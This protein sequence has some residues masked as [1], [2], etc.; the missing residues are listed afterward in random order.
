MSGPVRLAATS[1]L[2]FWLCGF[3]LP[4]MLGGSGAAAPSRSVR[5]AVMELTNVSGARELDALGKGL[6]SLLATDLA[7]AQAVQMVERE[8]LNDIL[9]EARLARAG[10]SDGKAASRVGKLLGATHLAT[11][12][13]AV[14]GARLR[15]DLRVFSVETGEIVVAESSEGEKDAFFEV[16]GALVRQI[17]ARLAVSLEPREREALARPQ[18]SS[19]GAL[20]DFSAGIDLFDRQRYD[21]AVASLRKAVERDQDFKLARAT[22]DRYERAAAELRRSADDVLV[23]DEEA[24]RLA[25]RSAQDAESALRKQLFDALSAPGDD[26]DARARRAMAAHIL[27]CQ[28]HGS[29]K[30]YLTDGDDF[31]ARR[32]F[33]VMARHYYREAQVVYPR[34][35]LAI[36]CERRTEGIRVQWPSHGGFGPASDMRD[37]LGKARAWPGLL[38]LDIRGEAEL[39]DRIAERGAKVGVDPSIHPDWRWESLER[40]SAAWQSLLELERSTRALREEATL[41][42]HDNSAT[43]KA[44]W[45]RTLAARVEENARL[46]SGPAAAKAEDLGREYVML[47]LVKR[48][49]YQ[50]GDWSWGEFDGLGTDP[51]FAPNERDHRYSLPGLR[52]VEGDDY[53]L[54]GDTP[55]W[56]MRNRA[57]WNDGSGPHT[58]DIDHFWTGRRRD[59]LRADE[60]RYYGSPGL[61]AWQ[62]EA[63]SV[64][65]VEGVPRRELEARFEIDLTLPT[66][67]PAT[68]FDDDI[69]QGWTPGRPRL[70]FFFRG[71][72]IDCGV[73]PMAAIG[74][75]FAGDRVDLVEISV[76]RRSS[77]LDPPALKVLASQAASRP[78]SP[79]TTVAVR[80]E[81]DQALV[82][83]NGRRLSFALP[84]EPPSGFYGFLIWKP[85][86]VAIRDLRAGPVGH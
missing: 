63:S 80:I 32:M 75:A 4:A 71:R 29:K 49:R 76:R 70:V 10:V 8:H 61:P 86:F 37:D 41:P 9:G 22:L 58:R 82:T 39:L 12:S 14:V 24:K 33:E 78:S 17:L 65:V 51:V 13:F 7:K 68:V 6:Q 69:P 31:A 20:R 11:G 77:A 43:D 44:M 84:A 16:E 35:P 40:R 53:V 48:S 85:G 23:A 59:P 50:A 81:R 25:L 72:C 54:I 55:V 45:L 42:V 83:V 73:R 62:T 3:A 1:L 57:D 66:D 56:S 67:L 26:P 5:V 28:Y 46:A 2:A 27:A 52:R 64:L 15:I 18:T 38:H 79:R 60:V 21:E 36:D 47:A 30:L 19:F 74:L 34:V